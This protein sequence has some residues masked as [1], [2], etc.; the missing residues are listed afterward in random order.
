MRATRRRLAIGALALAL[1]ASACGGS[2]KPAASQPA[3]SSSTTTTTTVPTPTAEQAALVA[4][5]PFTVQVPVG[6]DRA[7]PAPLLVLLHGYG[8]SGAVQDAYL[9]LTPAAAK[10][11]VLYVYLDG[12]KNGQDKRFWNATDACCD[13]GN[14][15]VDDSAYIT[16]VIAE[17]KSTHNVDPKRVFLIGHSN[18]AFMSFRMACD[19]ADEIAAIV[20][21]EGATWLDPSRCHPSEP[22][23]ILAVHGTGDRTIEYAGGSAI[24]EYPSAATTVKTWAG[25]DGCRTQADASAP[26]SR[27]IVKDLAPATVLAYSTGCRGNGHVELWTQPDG[28]HIP[29][30]TDDFADQ[31]IAFLLAH[32]KR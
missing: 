6:Y 20:S 22:V 10:N 5:R 32:P 15:K 12:T 13:A 25:Y 4:A 7:K 27:S 31:M 28:V 26:P 3:K 30:W 8:A 21:L 18:G 14:P 2:S 29:L 24:A 1:G 9:K 17:V 11:G 19:H 16:A 23:A